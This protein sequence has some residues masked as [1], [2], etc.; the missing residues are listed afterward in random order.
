[1]VDTSSSSD[2]SILRSPALPKERN[3]KGR[4]RKRIRTSL[5]LIGMLAIAITVVAKVTFNNNVD[6]KSKQVAEV[7][8][9]LKRFLQSAAEAV[10]QGDVDSLLALHDDGYA[11]ESEGL[12]EQNLQSEQ[13][14]VHV[15]AWSEADTKSFRK[16][17]L[18]AQYEHHLATVGNIEKSE[19]KLS[20]IEESSDDGS[21]VIRAVLW[22]RG[23]TSENE[24]RESRATFRLQL[25]RHKGEWRIQG[26]KLLQGLTVVGTGRGF[27]NITQ[28]AGIRFESRPNPMMKQP[29]WQPKR[30][31]IF[32]HGTAGVATA[33]YDN[34]GWYD[35]FFCDGAMPRL[36]RNR[37]DGGFEDVTEATGLPSSLNGVNVA[38]FADFDND[39]DRDL[40]VGRLTGNNCLFRNE[41]NGKFTDVSEQANVSGVWVTTAAAADYNNDGLVDLYMGRYLDPRTDL[42]TTNFYA[43]NGKGNTLLRNN[44][45]LRFTDVTEE[46]GVRDGGLT[47]GIAAG[48]YDNDGDQDFYVANDFGRNALFRNNADGTFTDVA[49]ESGTVD[50]GY[51]MSASFEDIDNDGDLDIYVAGVHSG[52]RWFGN[53]ITIKQYLVN[54]VRE[55][56]FFGDLPLFYDIDRMVDF[57]WTNFGEQIISGNSLMLNN[58]NGKFSDV[59]DRSLA[60]PHGWFWG[61]GAFDFDNDSWQDIYTVNGWITGEVKDDL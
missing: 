59:T 45:N 15:Y 35:I 34:D 55:G 24:T 13:D 61:S 31:E 39:G 28:Q 5:I 53:A 17:D 38:I 43:R 52:Q 22:L 19:F 36:Y 32:K 1:M 56:T 47:L 2:N 60:N 30:F 26:K 18:R 11:T 57:D 49:L 7:G 48:D 12:W 6:V 25:S 10:K 4:W 16:S 42:P 20:S 29:E 44:G 3:T 8:T 9:S 51:G 58:G 33:D 37:G 23:A 50:V 27:E 46:A 21:A 14:G 41:G 54:S 40:F